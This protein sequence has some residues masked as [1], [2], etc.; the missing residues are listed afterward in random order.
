LPVIVKHYD[1]IGGF[2]LGKD[3]PKAW[4]VPVDVIYGDLSGSIDSI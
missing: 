3:N 4:N 1:D 2:D